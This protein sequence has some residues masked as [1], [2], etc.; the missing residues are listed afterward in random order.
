MRIL[1]IL[2]GP[3]GHRA[4]ELAKAVGATRRSVTL[5]YGP[6]YLAPLRYI[7]LFLQTLIVLRVENPDTVYAQNPPIF[8]PLTCLLFCRLNGKSLVVD[9]HSVWRVKT[10]GGILGGLIGYIEG[11]VSRMASANTAPHGVWAQELSRMGARNVLVIHDHVERNPYARDSEIRGD[12]QV[13]NF[14][15][16]ASHGGHPLERIESEV[17]A[18][19]ANPK[20]TL[21]FTGP[22]E[23]LKSRFASLK[24]PA[25]ARYLGMLPMQ[26]YLRLKAS[27]D[28]A[29]NI[30]DEPHTLSHVIFEYFACGLPV[31]S[32]RQSVVKDVFGDSVLYVNGSSAGEVAAKVKE[33][34]ET[35]GLLER[36]RQN[37]A[38]RYMQ[39]ETTREAEI[40]R[41][42]I[43]L[44]KSARSTALAS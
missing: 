15:A 4:D 2:W 29:I 27:C 22:E 36:Y 6:R 1:V 10:L 13:D 39:L 38:A 9:H 34:L 17:G 44:S 11:F 19:A 7:A 31:I 20:L 25:N 43:M 3:F 14:L 24:L 8:C 26:E 41:L 40:S 33:V 5:F 12:Y 42:R 30:T 32:S 37:V 28:F 23:K 16:I 18:A 35:K 21:L